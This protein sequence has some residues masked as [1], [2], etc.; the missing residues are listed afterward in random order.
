MTQKIAVIV[1]GGIVQSVVTNDEALIGQ[2]IL[3]ID[4]DI[5]GCDLDKITA[6]DQGDGTTVDAYVYG[7]V[8]SIERAAIDLDK[9][10]E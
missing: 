6:I 4:Y 5:D 8:T 1:E 9:I 3:I 7:G 10:D 2:K